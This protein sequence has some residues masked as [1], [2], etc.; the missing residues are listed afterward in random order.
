VLANDKWKEGVQ[1]YLA[2]ISF[3]DARVGELL[4]AL[5][6]SGRADNTIIVLLG[7]HGFHLGEKGR[8]R[9]S[10]LWERS[11]H[12]PL[13]IVAPGV[14]TAGSKTRA[15]VSLMDVYPTF[16]GLDVPRHVEGQS[17]LTLLEDP[18]AESDRPAV[19][20]YG[21]NNHAIRSEQFRYIRYADGN[22]ELYD[23][24]ADPNEFTNLADDPDY[25]RIK[26]DLARWIPR[27][28][29][30]DLARPRRLP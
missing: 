21:F 19:T 8:W 29:A 23:D 9:K 25:R 28:N 15:P 1:G 11:T 3:A 16:A 27:D 5:D 17:L 13:I 6:R 20:T 22:E 24:V 30:P 18:T 2:S 26:R 14:T 4:D 10:T 7:D 12:V